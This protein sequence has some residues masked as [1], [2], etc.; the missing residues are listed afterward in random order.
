MG[1]Q[2]ISKKRWFKTMII[3]HVAINVSDPD[4][5][6]EW[7]VKVLGMKLLRQANEYTYFIADERESTVLEIYHNPA[8]PVPDYKNLDP[9][10]LHFAF[11]SDDLDKDMQRLIQAGAV[12]QKGIATTKEGDRLAMLRDPWGVCIQLASRAPKNRMK[13]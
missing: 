5:M 1:K 3:E 7:Y 2:E 10:I 9:L 4:Q 11:I 8:A 13:L 6:V 12:L